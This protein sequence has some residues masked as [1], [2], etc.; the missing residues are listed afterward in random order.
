MRSKDT[1]SSGGT[2]SVA[3]AGGTRPRQSVALQPKRIALALIF[4]V[5]G[6]LAVISVYATSYYVDGTRGNNANDGLT[7]TTTKKNIS[8]ALA[9]AGSGDVIQVASS[10]YQETS[11][12]PSGQQL[13][14]SSAGPVIVYQTD[15]WMT[16]TDGDGLPDAW[17]V[18][19][20]LDAFSANGVNGAEGDADNDGVSN[21]DEFLAG[22]NPQHS[23]N[24]PPTITYTITP[25]PNA[26]GWNTN[27]MTVRFS[28]TDNESGVAWVSGDVSIVGET[29]GAEVVGIA[30]DNAGNAVT[31]CVTVN[32]DKTAP[33]ISGHP[34]D[35]ET[36]HNRRAPIV[37]Q[38]TDAGSGVA[39]DHLNVILDGVDISASFQ[40]FGKGAIYLPQAEYSLGQHSL[41]VTVADVAGNAVT[42]GA[43]F[44][45]QV[46]TGGPA[47]T[48]FDLKDGVT[49]APDVSEIWVQGRRRDTS[50]T[51]SASV[52]FDPPIRMNVQDLDFGYYLPLEPGT[53]VIVLTS[54]NPT[55]KAFLVERSQ[56]YQVEMFSPTFGEFANGQP[57]YASGYITVNPEAGMPPGLG[58]ASVS[59]NGVAAE[60]YE[61]GSGGG[62]F[63]TSD[64]GVE[65]IAQS[66]R[67]SF[68]FAGPMGASTP[69]F[70]P[71]FR[72]G[73]WKATR[74]KVSARIT[75]TSRW[76][77]RNRTSTGRRSA[78]PA[79]MNCR[80]SRFRFILGTGN[81]SLT[82]PAPRR[83]A[84]CSTMCRFTIPR[85]R[86]SC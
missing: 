75:G 40:R 2:R 82:C 61:D 13:Q 39:P 60:L 45:V 6:V 56:W 30:V 54:S 83:R 73:C 14:L 76:N 57:K 36:E 79:Q 25:T 68:R 19:Y 21:L 5:L 49:V 1:N 69:R 44:T 62:Y 47:I 65:P 72:W 43:V 66:C 53:N 33:S 84:T 70:V 35:Q 12:P 37:V 78:G 59:V 18:K 55:T 22:T 63:M 26:A 31:M 34:G 24:T 71:R 85:T 81:T 28:A 9:V 46:P 41:T 17:E 32:I 27:D 50:I 38:Y 23:D 11:W 52:N 67:S 42:A 7:P 80:G 64:A 3:S 20:G 74:S 29:N 86:R 10:I 51:V 58:L 15:P 48:D 8:A 16:D 4:C 77:T